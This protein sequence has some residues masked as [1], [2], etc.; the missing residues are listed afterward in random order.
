MRELCIKKPGRKR[1]QCVTIQVGGTTIT[2]MS[3]PSTVNKYKNT[4]NHAMIA[5]IINIPIPNTLVYQ[6]DEINIM[7]IITLETL[8]LKNL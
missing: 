2:L 3:S 1:K 6:G 4:G 8:Q 7:N 5:S